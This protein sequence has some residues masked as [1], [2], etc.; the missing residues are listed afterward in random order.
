M[1]EFPEKVQIKLTQL[2]HSVWQQSRNYH[3][4]TGIFDKHTIHSINTHVHTYTHP[5]VYSIARR[6]SHD[7]NRK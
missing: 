6:T 1:N 2:I 7:H 3:P 4:Q 5:I